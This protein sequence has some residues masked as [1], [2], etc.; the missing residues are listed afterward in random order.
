MPSHGIASGH[1]PGTTMA[2]PRPTGGTNRFLERPLTLVGSMRSGTTML[3]LML[4]GHPEIAFNSEFEYAFDLMTDEASWPS[5]AAFRA[6][7]N[8]H[9]FSRQEGWVINPALNYPELVDSLLRQ[10][11][12][13]DGKALVGAT[14]HLDFDRVL[15]VWPDA[16]FIHLLRDGRDVARSSIQMGW[17]GNMYTAVENWVQAEQL[18]LDL[19]RRVPA[20]RLYELKYEDLVAHPEATLTALCRFIGVPYDPAMLSYPEHTTYDLPSAAFAHQW[21]TKLT[22]AEVALAE[23]RIGPMLVERGYELSGHPTPTLPAWKVAI[24][25]LQSRLRTFEFRRR[26]HGTGLCLAFALAK[27]TGPES[28]RRAL[29]RRIDDIDLT[30]AK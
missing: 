18:W 11:R 17:A 20:D 8:H 14:V 2:A 21:R 25:R 19:G 7:L 13:R 23:A 5:P 27:R 10:K 16:R 6:Y 9:P 26:R 4:D 12:D 3:R 28:W 24:H 22:P 29:E 30:F 1:K 15:R